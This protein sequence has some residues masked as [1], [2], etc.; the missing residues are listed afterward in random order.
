[1]LKT[2]TSHSTLLGL[3][4]LALIGVATWGLPT[5]T[6]ENSMPNSVRK[7]D[8]TICNK[9]AFV[10][11]LKQNNQYC[12]QIYACD[13]QSTC[14]KDPQPY[15]CNAEAR[16]FFFAQTEATNRCFEL[17]AKTL[18]QRKEGPFLRVCNLC[19]SYFADEARS[20]P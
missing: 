17:F 10:K 14:K 6:T 7:E 5:P 9:R 1:M 13:Q 8:T 20:V 19:S 4:L 12:A 2:T 16:L 15:A 18:S 11:T 3:S